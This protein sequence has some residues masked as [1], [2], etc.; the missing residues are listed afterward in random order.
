MAENL[1]IESPDFGRIKKDA[2]RATEDAIRLLW[3][4]QNDE[5]AQRRRGVRAAR[6]RYRPKLLTL[7]PT[8]QQDD[9]ETEG[10]GIIY[11]TGSTNFSLTGLRAI[12]EG[13]VVILVN[14]G[15]ATITVENEHAGS[16]AQ[17]RI[18][19]AAGADKTLATNKAI[20][21]AYLN[22]RFREL[23]LA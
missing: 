10:A 11:F 3:F 20:I 18:V 5:I 16:D 15:S 19:M 17:N 21:L 12:E 23:S 2:G 13:D 6:D 4:V 7:A 14:L 8:A 9:L 1:S 22:T